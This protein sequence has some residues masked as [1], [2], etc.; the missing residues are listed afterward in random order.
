MLTMNSEKDVNECILQ[1]PKKLVCYP[2]DIKDD[3]L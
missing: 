2:D 3:I 1:T